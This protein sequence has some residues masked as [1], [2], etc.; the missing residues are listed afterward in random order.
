MSSNCDKP[1]FM[2]ISGSGPVDC[3]NLAFGSTLPI[4]V[5]YDYDI[6]AWTEPDCG[7][8]GIGEFQMSR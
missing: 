7:G 8:T 5:V 2:N 4:G 6:T 3:A 1:S